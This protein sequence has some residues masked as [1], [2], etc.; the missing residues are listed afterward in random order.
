MLPLRK[1]WLRF[2]ATLRKH[3]ELQLLLFETFFWRQ[4]SGVRGLFV[5]TPLP[6]TRPELDHLPTRRERQ[7]FERF[8]FFH[9]KRYKETQ[10]G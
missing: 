8:R 7:S 6:D 5:R 1:Q 4:V 9:R 10:T 2:L 3:R